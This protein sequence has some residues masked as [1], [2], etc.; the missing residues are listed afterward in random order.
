MSISQNARLAE[1]VHLVQATGN[2]TLASAAGAGAWADVSKASRMTVII[3]VTNATTVNAGDVVLEQAQDASGTGARTLA[4]AK[5]WRALDVA[6]DQSLGQ[7]AVV[8]N[9]F[10]TDTTNSKRLRYVIDVDAAGLD[11]DGGFR[12]ARCKVTNSANSVGQISYVLAPSRY[13]IA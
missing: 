2:A 12:F 7:F 8:S 13:S 10:K 11:S 1:L 5:A 9:T 3:D 6:A 4:F